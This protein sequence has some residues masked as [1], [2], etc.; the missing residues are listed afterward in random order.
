MSSGKNVLAGGFFILVC[1][2]GFAF[3]NT[4]CGKRGEDRAK[5]PNQAE[6]PKLTTNIEAKRAPQ[7]QTPEKKPYIPT[8]KKVRVLYSFD[9]TTDG[10]EVPDWAMDEEGYV[11]KKASVS[12]DVMKDGAASLK[13]DAEFPGKV[14]TAALVEVMEYL[15]L[16]QYSEMSCDIYIPKETPPGLKAKIIV[17]VGDSWKFTEMARAIQLMPGEWTRVKA[18]LLAGSDDWKGTTVDDSFRADVRKI[19]IRIESNRSPVYSGPIYIDN[20]RVSNP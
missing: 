3:V 18:N 14:W 7:P 13:V 4:G 19:A 16:T 1:L 2:V 5:A 6:K 12:N 20:I 11:A 9:K 15:D 8:E 10:W 17:T